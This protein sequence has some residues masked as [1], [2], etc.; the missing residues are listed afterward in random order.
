MH[1]LDL[2]LVQTM[3]VTTNKKFKI[4]PLLN[5]QTIFVAYDRP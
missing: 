1:W 2:V 5:G 4:W 3:E